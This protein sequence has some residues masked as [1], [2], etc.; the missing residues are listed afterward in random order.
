MQILKY[1]ITGEQI[2]AR[3]AL[4]KMPLDA[5]FLDAQQ[6]RNQIVVWVAADQMQVGRHRQ[7]TMVM[8]GGNPPRVPY[9]AT[10]QIDDGDFVVHLFDHG[11][12]YQTDL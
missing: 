5:V 3:K 4:I 10:V 12:T 8:T 7:I 6:Q 2:S 9:I 11:Y 1:T